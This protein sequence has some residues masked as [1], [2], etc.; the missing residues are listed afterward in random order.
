MKR[1]II[2]RVLIWAAAVVL[3][4]PVLLYLVLIAINWHDREL[5]PLAIKMMD[6]Y[7]ASSIVIKEDNGYV[8]VM[9]FAVAP[10]DDPHAMGLK[11][12][13]WISKVNQIGKSQAGFDPQEREYDFK[14]KR[15]PKVE[16]I[17]RALNGSSH[18]PFG[19]VDW[20]R[21]VDDIETLKKWIASESWL[22]ERYQRL[23]EQSRWIDQVPTDISLPFPPFGTVMDGQR[24]LMAK[25]LVLAKESRTLEMNQ[26]LA[27]DLR[28]WRRVL[29]ST[30]MLITKMIAVAALDRHFSVAN[31]SLRQ[32]SLDAQRKAIP[33]E[34]MQPISDEEKSLHKVMIG[35]WIFATSLMKQTNDD[36]WDALVDP[37]SFDQAPKH[38]WYSLLGKPL[39][40]YQDTV[41]SFAESY[42]QISNAG[43]VNY[44]SLRS[45]ITRI[46]AEIDSQSAGKFPIHSAYN[47]IGQI[48]VAMSQYSFSDYIRRVADIEGVRRATLAAIELRGASVKL[49]DLPSALSKSSQRNPYT[50]EPFSWDAKEKVIVFKGLEKGERGEHHAYF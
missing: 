40:R 26:L 41:N 32:L 2:K 4:I 10:D 11:R 35:E 37:P 9:G 8:D 25:V 21:E 36:D 45:S 7:R 13:E 27:S 6:E 33:E 29:S 30:N 16:A 24:V 39:Y 18:S 22:L 34:W 15:D 46:D 19:S 1:V 49:E 12:V 38:H 43:D 50:N 17:A 48:L 5:S 3:G 20:V 44:K 23:L 14:S 28:F 42:S 31:F 47:P